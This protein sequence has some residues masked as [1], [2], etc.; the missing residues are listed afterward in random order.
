MCP[1]ILMLV[2]H[3]FLWNLNFDVALI[4]TQ[5][6]F[7][8][9]VNLIPPYF[10]VILIYTL[11]LFISKQINFFVILI[12]FNLTLKLFVDDITIKRKFIY[13]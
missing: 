3:T 9:D 2:H 6:R 12:S 1:T 7:L 10:T 13:I 5:F 4:A 8:G 11:T